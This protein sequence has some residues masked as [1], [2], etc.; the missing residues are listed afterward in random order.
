MGTRKMEAP[1]E[2]HHTAPRCLLRL[3]G[4]ANGAA[5]GSDLNGEAIQAWLEWEMEAMR[6][7]VPVEISR[8][9]LD[10][11]VGSSAE[12]MERK[13]HRLL[14]ESDWQRWGSWGGKETVRRYGSSWMA[15]LALKRWGRITEADLD[16]ARVLR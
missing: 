1:L 6:W 14:H 16:A 12:L 7:R 2:A 8:E 4:K 13:R 9:D 15:L 5:P 10:A 11:L 3:H